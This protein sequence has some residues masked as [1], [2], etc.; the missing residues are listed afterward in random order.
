LSKLLSELAALGLA[1]HCAQEL[2]GEEKDAIG[3]YVSDAGW[4]YLSRPD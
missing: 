3:A 2:A 1:A 4:E